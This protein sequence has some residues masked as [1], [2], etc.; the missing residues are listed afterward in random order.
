MK[1]CSIEG[2]NKK[3][4]AKGYCSKHYT[5]IKRYGEIKRTKYDPNEIIIHK[6]YAEIVIYNQKCEEVA[7][8]LIDID[9]VERC[10]QCKWFFTGHGYIINSKYIKLHRFIMNCS[11]GMVVDHINHNKLDNRKCNLRICTQQ[12][13]CM[14]V[15]SSIK[16]V[17]FDKS[18][19]KWLAH[20][21]GKNLGRFDTYEDALKVRK[22]AEIKYFGEYRNQD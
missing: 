6:D 3:H 4:Y 13:N 15:S 11:K 20:I 5:Q 10:K 8:T 19:N 18:R 9:D 12:E 7:R 16:G 1:E 14:N 17:C 2:C 21:K 22:D